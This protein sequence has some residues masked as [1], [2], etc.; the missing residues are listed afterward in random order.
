MHDGISS[1]VVVLGLWAAGE[2][3]LDAHAIAERHL[4]A[5]G[6][7]PALQ[8]MR[9]RR[10]SGTF[11]APDGAT[12]QYLSERKRPNLCRTESRS[13]DRGTRV[14]GYNGKTAWSVSGGDAVRILSGAEAEEQ[15]DACEFDE[16]PLLDFAKRGIGVVYA[17][18]VNVDGT[19][20]HK[21]DIVTPSGAKTVLYIDRSTW[22]EFRTDYLERDG[23]V[24]VQRV[25][26]RKVVAGVS[27]ATTIVATDA[28]GAYPLRLDV[29]SIQVNVPI[30]DGRFDPPSS[31]MGNGMPS[32]KQ[33][34]P[35]RPG[36][37]EPRP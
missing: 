20:A 26:E 18:P 23:T 29:D 37:V 27:F 24:I 28:N 19:P 9:S 15:I 8:A 30:P 16:T 3:L 7:A 13:A 22:R 5:L 32:D 1:V 36:P 6:G 11:T 14:R 33:L 35:T 4:K 17:G 34:R 10:M 12:R 31:L 2:P 21:L 25:V